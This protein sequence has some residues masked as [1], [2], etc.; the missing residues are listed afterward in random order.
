[1]LCIVGVNHRTYVAVGYKSANFES[2]Q[3]LAYNMLSAPNPK[4]EV[5]FRFTRSN[6]TYTVKNVLLEILNYKTS[7]CKPLGSWNATIISYSPNSHNNIV[8]QK[9]FSG[10]S[11]HVLEYS[12][13]PQQ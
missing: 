4:L 11:C 5:F 8:L 10:I 3:V 2:T 9:I 6:Y 1:M 12:D 7:H 13:F